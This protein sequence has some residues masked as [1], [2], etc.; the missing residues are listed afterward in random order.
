MYYYAYE[1]APK[2]V[3][4][5]IQAFNL[6]AQGSISGA[7]T[8]A[9]QLAFVPNNLNTGNLNIYYYVNVAVAVLGM[10]L[11]GLYRHQVGSSRDFVRGINLET[12]SS[13]HRSL[14][15]S[16]AQPPTRRD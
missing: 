7:F 16:F 12:G 10:A 2:K 3:R 1:A 9:L 6:V 4:A 11:Y 14:V 8:A 13:A 5:T 15:G